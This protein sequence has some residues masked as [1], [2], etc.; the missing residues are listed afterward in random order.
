MG[1]NFLLVVSIRRDL[2]AL[3]VL[4]QPKVLQIHTLLPTT[5]SLE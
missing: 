5:T 4:N 2:E 1:D 3:K